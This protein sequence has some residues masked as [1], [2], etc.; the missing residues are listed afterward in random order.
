MTEALTKIIDYCFSN[1]DLKRLEAD[2]D[3]DNA[4]SAAVL[5]K[6]DSCWK[7]D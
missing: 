7:E 3:P 6:W 4:A 2:I 1:L 5:K